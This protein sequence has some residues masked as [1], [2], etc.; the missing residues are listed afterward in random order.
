MLVRD[1]RG[2]LSDDS[3]EVLWWHHVLF[4]L[5]VLS[6]TLLET[7]LCAF[8]LWDSCAV[9]AVAEPLDDTLGLDVKKLQHVAL[10]EITSGV[11]GCSIFVAI[12]LLSDSVGLDWLLFVVASVYAL[13][14]LAVRCL[15]PAP[16]SFS[17]FFFG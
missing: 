5:A 8:L 3:G 13:M 16:F 12:L 10:F 11:V 14:L 2:I 4:V 6:C 1:I 15:G 7:C 17:L 9:R